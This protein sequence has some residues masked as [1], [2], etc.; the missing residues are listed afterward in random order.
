MTYSGLPSLHAILEELPSE[1]DSA[2]SEGESSSSPLPRACNTMTS[3]V[4]ITTMLPL[5]GTPMFETLL[6]RQQRTATPTTLL[7]Q[8]AA[9]QEE[10]RCAPQD[11]IK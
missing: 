2:S 1:D 9:H 4:P 6:M 5:E 7:E 11:D 3:A 10:R 8:L